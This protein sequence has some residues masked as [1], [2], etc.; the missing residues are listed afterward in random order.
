MSAD[1]QANPTPETDTE[2]VRVELAERAYDI[3]VGENVIANAAEYIGTVTGGRK[4]RAAVVSDETVAK[5]HLPALTGALDTAG[6]D[7]Q[8][9]IV[10]V[11]EATKSFGQFEELVDG[12]LAARIERGDVVIALGG[13]VVGDL[14]GFAAA[15][16]RRGIDVIQAPT[17]LLAQVDSSVGGKTAIN[18]PRGKNL[19]GVF[20]QPRLVLVDISVLGTLPVRDIKA[21]FAE[22]LKYGL[23]ND[24]EFFAWLESNGDALLSGDPAA[25]R[26][27]VITSCRSKARI[28]AADEREGGVR[29]LL[30]L[31]HTFGHALEAEM[32]YGDGILHGEAVGIGMR[33]AFDL[34]ARLGLCPQAD[35]DRV[36]ACLRKFDMAAT[37]KDIPGHSQSGEWQAERLLHHMRQ[38]KKVSVGQLTFVLARGIGEAFVTREVDEAEL[39]SALRQE[40][41]GTVRR[42]D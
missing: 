6:I 3:V 29:A 30:N 28:V 8:A 1:S 5:L 23:I 42:D 21:G 19:I 24:V 33:M 37:V 35:A 4:L 39:M 20:H 40:V 41:A 18:S 25:R 16:V 27:A 26:E 22:V 38:D 31:G 2:T 15:V 12:I 13:G 7:H 32:G 34:S 11:G 10:P 36:H 9:L 14:A 17:T